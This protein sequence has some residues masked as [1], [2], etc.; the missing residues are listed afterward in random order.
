M[1]ASR[2]AA[3]A[4]ACAVSFICEAATVSP[5]TTVDSENKY[6]NVGALMVWRVD[7]AG[8]PIELRGFA[9]GTLI[10]DRVVVTA[11]HFTAPAT[12]L[13]TLP[14]SIRIF[15]SFSATSAKDP[16]TWIR[17]VA[18]ATHPSMPHCPPPPKCDPTDELLVAPLQPGIADVGLVFLAQAPIGAK[19]A[20][21]AESGILER[22]EGSSTTIVGYGTTSPGRR[23]PPIDPAAWDG[24][25]RFRVS[26]VRRIVDETWGLWS[27]PSY[28]CHGDSGG[29]IFLNRGPGVAD[30]GV[31]A[32][33]VSD[34]GQDCRS[35]NNNNRLDTRSVQGWI[36]DT[37]RRRRDTLELRSLPRR[38]NAALSLEVQLHA[39]DLGPADRQPG[40]P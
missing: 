28:V 17:V 36:D 1:A 12:A 11:G 16:E 33:S 23:E 20:R 13:G 29:A 19:P 9:S 40:G 8:N 30:G 31:L 2:L 7:D 4:A 6:S 37:I 34:G 27:I 35:H 14:P 39:A 18:W 24:K 32:A 5:Q 21:L 10:R 25:R 3:L 15:A 26:T 38:T 22:L